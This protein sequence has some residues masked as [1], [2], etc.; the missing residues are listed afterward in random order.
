MTFYLENGAV[1]FSQLN[2]VVAG[3]WV[4]CGGTINLGAG[5]Q[6]SF[7]ITF[8]IQDLRSPVWEGEERRGG[9]LERWNY[10][11]S[12]NATD[13]KNLVVHPICQETQKVGLH[14]YGFGGTWF[15]TAVSPPPCRTV[16]TTEAVANSSV[17]AVA[18]ELAVRPEHVVVTGW[19]RRTEL[20]QSAKMWNKFNKPVLQRR[21]QAD[22][23]RSG[24]RTSRWRRSIRRGPVGR[25]EAPCS[26]G[27]RRTTAGSFG[28]TFRLCR[29]Q[30]MTGGEK[31]MKIFVKWSTESGATMLNVWQ[32]RAKGNMQACAVCYL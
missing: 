2:A 10:L 8:Q 29:L 26:S 1:W 5:V 31:L 9:K 30:N 11:Y 15:L 13:K 18:A 17:L 27:Q 25:S 32:G 16:T 4:A 19:R 14:G 20:W 21:M 24:S 7:Q 23:S 22:P 3:Q 12:Y 6:I 28:Q